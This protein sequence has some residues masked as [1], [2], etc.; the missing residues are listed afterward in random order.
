M[1]LD[2]NILS[3]IQKKNCVCHIKYNFYFTLKHFW[4]SQEK[5]QLIVI[6]IVPC[7]QKVFLADTHAPKTNR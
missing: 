2:G 1:I 3:E 5:S 4:G 7:I 6:E